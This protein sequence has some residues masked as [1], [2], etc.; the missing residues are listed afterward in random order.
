MRRRTR[1]KGG[2]TIITTRKNVDMQNTDYKHTPS[3]MKT[4]ATKEQGV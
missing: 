2:M 1:E 3:T 4:N